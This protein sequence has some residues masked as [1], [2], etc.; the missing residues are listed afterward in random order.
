MMIDLITPQPVLYTYSRLHNIKLT[1]LD[2]SIAVL[3]STT[4]LFYVLPV[5][6]SLRVF[7]HHYKTKCDQ[8]NK[9]PMTKNSSRQEFILRF[10]IEE[11][12]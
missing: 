2:E 9:N 6:S 5:V 12:K 8:S 11:N 3:T 10:V 1:L 7:E 4:L